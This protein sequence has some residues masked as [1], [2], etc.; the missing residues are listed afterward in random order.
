MSDWDTGAAPATIGELRR[1][2]ESLGRPWDVPARFS[3]DDPL[4]QAPTG[5]APIEPGHVE[6]LR[7]IS[8]Q[9]EFDEHLRAVPPTNP[10]L[11]ERWRE[12]GLLPTERSPEGAAQ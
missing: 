12:L 11:V 7:A 4:P 9:A 5:G 3:D 1:R 2:L 10:F 8:S 6:G